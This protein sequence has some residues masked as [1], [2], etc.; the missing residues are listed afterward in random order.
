MTHGWL[1]LRGACPGIFILRH[2]IRIAVELDHGI[3]HVVL[4]AAK[5]LEAAGYQDDQVIT[6][7][8]LKMK[9]GVGRCGRC[10]IGSKY[11]CTDGPVFR[12]S[13]LKNMP[14]EY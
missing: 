13:D 14:A 9:C 3:R 7:L 2:R 5:D 1:G 11:V 8:E 6:T 4:G 10:N 12:L